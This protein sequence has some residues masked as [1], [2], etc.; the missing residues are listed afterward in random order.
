VLGRLPLFCAFSFVPWGFI[1]CEVQFVQAS[2]SLH[3]P[4]WLKLLASGL[5]VLPLV[6][7]LL[8]G[9]VALR[10][11]RTQR[12]ASLVPGMFLYLFF[13]AAFAVASH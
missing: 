1:L 12:H 6:V 3:S 13:L 4:D 10:A 7:G 9:L 5:F 2:A 11:P 8:I